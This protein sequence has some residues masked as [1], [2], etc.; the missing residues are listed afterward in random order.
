MKQIRTMIVMAAFLAGT[1]FTMVSIGQEAT[2]PAAGTPAAG[3]PSTAPGPIGATVAAAEKP[4]ESKMT[5][6]K[7]WVVGG[8]AMY[9]IAALSIGMVALIVYG[10]MNVKEDKMVRSDLLPQLHD[11][12][13]K[14]D[15]RTASTLC[16]GTMIASSDSPLTVAPEISSVFV[17]SPSP[18]A[19]TRQPSE[20]QNANVQT[21]ISRSCVRSR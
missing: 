1:I 15:F 12:I 21:G 19:A 2:A 5:L 14:L 6:W 8:W 7:L 9:P 3:A 20:L 13:R 4:K 18:P 16:S 11:S 10:F 17:E